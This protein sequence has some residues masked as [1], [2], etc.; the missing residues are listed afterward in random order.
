MHSRTAAW[1][2]G[3][4]LLF[5]GAACG[6]DDEKPAPQTKDQDAGVSGRGGAGGST[7]AGSGGGGS[8]GGGSGGHGGQGGSRTPGGGRGGGGGYAGN[9][10]AGSDGGR[11]GIGGK[12]GTDDP[13][14]ACSIT[15]SSL[16]EWCSDD[17]EHCDLRF[18]DQFDRL[19]DE[20]MRCSPP[21]TCVHI[22]VG[23]NSCGGSSVSATYGGDAYVVTS[24]YDAQARLVGVEA[25]RGNQCVIGARAAPA[26]HLY[27]AEC[28]LSDGRA[29]VCPTPAA[30]GGS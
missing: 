2:L 16:E 12:A 21:F 27:G 26:R 28:K 8:G 29:A 18:D 23:S 20:G 19:C 13:E 30:D 1:A 11:G 15:R 14:V 9:A 5:G 7:G 4:M 3:S 17:E 10:E 22:G 24:H 25:T 6:D